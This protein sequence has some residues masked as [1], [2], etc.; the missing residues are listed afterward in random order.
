[1]ESLKLKFDEDKANFC[2][3]ISNGGGAMKKDLLY[4]KDYIDSVDIRT[5]EFIDTFERVSRKVFPGCDQ[6][7]ERIDAL[8]IELKDVQKKS[9]HN[10]ITL[11]ALKEIT[12]ENGENI[13][14][15]K[16]DI[17]RLDKN[18][19][20]TNQYNRRQNLVIT[21]IPDYVP[22]DKLENLCLDI[23]HNVGF[24]Q[25]GAY[26]VVGCHRL[27]KKANDATTP[28]IIRF[29]NRKIPE[30]CLKNRWR[31]NN[32]KFNNWNLG[33]REDLCEENDIILAECEKLKNEGHLLKVYTHNGFVKVV[34]KYRD[35]PIK[36]THIND[37]YEM[38]S[39]I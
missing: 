25:V 16:D 14:S 29:V 31:L 19:S 7:E 23:I 18:I 2:H 12:T 10:Q 6:L 36:L 24:W 22:Q 27:K 32:M 30:F 34:K 33:F 15:A 21:G 13:K 20:A 38:F 11:E 8:E 9:C 17:V 35:R 3:I 26:E 39:K 37:V 28:T 5:E 4:L 1:M